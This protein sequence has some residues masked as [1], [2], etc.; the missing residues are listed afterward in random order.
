MRAMEDGQRNA[1]QYD[2]MGASYAAKNSAGSF[3]DQRRISDSQFY[4]RQIDA[5]SGETRGQMWRNRRRKV[6]RLRQNFPGS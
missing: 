5:N 1:S 2:A 6:I 4:F 3:N